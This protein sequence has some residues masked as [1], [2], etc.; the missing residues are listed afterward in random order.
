MKPSPC[1]LVSVHKRVGLLASKKEIIGAVVSASFAAAKAL[2]WL[3][4]H[5]KSFLVLRSGL[6][7]VSIVDNNNA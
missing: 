4:F 6:S 3:S 1:Q 2:S 5:R 7:G